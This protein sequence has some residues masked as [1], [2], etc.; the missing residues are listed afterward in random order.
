[1]AAPTPRL[2][3]QLL[4]DA[5]PSSVITRREGIV[6]SPGHNAELRSIARLRSSPWLISARE[7]S[8]S[9]RRPLFPLLLSSDLDAYIVDTPSC[10]ALH[11][12]PPPTSALVPPSTCSFS[13]PQNP[14]G[15]RSGTPCPLGHRLVRD[16]PLEYFRFL[17]FQQWACAQAPLLRGLCADPDCPPPALPPCLPL[18]SFLRWTYPLGA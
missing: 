1:M 14:N 2:N 13:A 4:A 17:V 10:C 16:I 6:P 18:S 8:S 11:S 7:S 15:R 3:E 5:T 12:P 9:M